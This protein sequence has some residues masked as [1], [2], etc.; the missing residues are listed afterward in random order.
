MCSKQPVIYGDGEQARDFVYVKDVVDANMLA[1]E[2]DC[3]G[4]I[5]NIASGSSV[6]INDLFKILQKTTGKNEIQP[7]Y[8]VPKKCEIRESCGD[9]S[10]AKSVLGFKPMVSIEEGLKKLAE[11]WKHS[12]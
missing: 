3:A 5:F 9:I 10:K 2:K 7:E 12:K 6:K 4:A 8:S 11:S 1:M